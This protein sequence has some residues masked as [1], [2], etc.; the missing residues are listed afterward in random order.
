MQRLSLD[1]QPPL[2]LLSDTPFTSNTSEFASPPLA[3]STSSVE[4]LLPIDFEDQLHPFTDAQNIPSEDIQSD[5]ILAKLAKGQGLISPPSRSQVGS[6][7]AFRAKPAP[8]NMMDSGVVGPRMSKA[9]ASRQG[10]QWDEK[11]GGRERR[12]VDFGNTPGHKRN[13]LS[14][15]S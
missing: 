10:L 11:Q 2:P 7:S 5:P 14:L 9:A 13:N 6:S 4:Q 15:V 3:S 8:S 1:D 12:E